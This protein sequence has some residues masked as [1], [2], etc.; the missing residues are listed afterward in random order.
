[1][2]KKVVELLNA[3]VNKEFFSAYL[4]LGISKFFTK[5]DLPGFASWY[6]VQAE[7]EQEHAMKF[8]EYLL[9]QDEDVTLEAIAEVKINL[10]DAL[11]A[12]KEADKHE[13]YIT[14]EIVKIMDAAVEAKDYRTQ[15]LLDWFI[16][17][18]EEEEKNSKEMIAK[19]E[20]LGNDKK[21]LY[22]L[23]KELGGR[24]AD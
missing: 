22:L 9:D 23:D 7:E 17:E 6:K 14:D 2:N 13:H 16:K 5:Q 15:L 8:Y 1:M 21:N 10:K 12:A 3:Q 18:Q 19:I 4:Y 24:K 11:D 20:M